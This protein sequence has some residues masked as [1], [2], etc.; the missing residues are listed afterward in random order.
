MITVKVFFRIIAIILMFLFVCLT[1]NTVEVEYLVETE[2]LYIDIY[3]PYAY[4]GFFG[5]VS[6]VSLILWN[7]DYLYNKLN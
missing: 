5:T 3:S 4:F 2:D 6:V 7:F 1:Y